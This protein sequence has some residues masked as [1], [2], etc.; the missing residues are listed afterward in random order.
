MLLGK[1]PAP[2]EERQVGMSLVSST[3]RLLVHYKET[4]TAEIPPVSLYGFS[5]IH[6]WFSGEAKPCSSP[7]SKVMALSVGEDL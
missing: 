6:A 4:G 3:E 1:L 2:R 7:C 5:S